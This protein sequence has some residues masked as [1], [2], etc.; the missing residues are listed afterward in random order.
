MKRNIEARPYDTTLEK[1]LSLEKTE[2]VFLSNTAKELFRTVDTLN[3]Q[4][5][6]HA[7]TIT[8]AQLELK[9]VGMVAKLK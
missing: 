6:T 9:G 3:S 5:I 4:I 2:L 8:H 1:E 7:D